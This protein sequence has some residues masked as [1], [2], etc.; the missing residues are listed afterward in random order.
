MD[1][2]CIDQ[3]REQMEM[4]ESPNP[5]HFFHRVYKYINW[6]LE[7]CMKSTSIFQ[8]TKKKVKNNCEVRDL[9]GLPNHCNNVNSGTS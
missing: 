7:K 8:N 9:A 1:L 2:P 3:T 5:S 6:A 4:D